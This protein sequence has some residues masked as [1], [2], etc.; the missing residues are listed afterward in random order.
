[1]FHLLGLDGFG[2]W[3]SNITMFNDDLDVPQLV[4]PKDRWSTTQSCRLGVFAT[5]W[6]A[7]RPAVNKPNKDIERGW[8]WRDDDAYGWLWIVSQ[9]NHP[10]LTLALNQSLLK[11]QP[12]LRGP[13]I[14]GSRGSRPCY[15][16]WF[17]THPGHHWKCARRA[18]LGRCAWVAA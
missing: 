7:W 5:S 10:G 12:P 11:V 16:R 1:M 8:L 14:S 4:L 13:P 2:R 9:I 3:I 17:S 15:W 6:W 18:H